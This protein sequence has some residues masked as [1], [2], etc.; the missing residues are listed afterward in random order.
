[1]PH[2]IMFR[3]DDFGLLDLREIA[4]GFPGAFE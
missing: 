4:L 3:D 1:V 2:P